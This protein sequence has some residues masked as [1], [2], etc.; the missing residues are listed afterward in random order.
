MMLVVIRIKL[1]NA[2]EYWCNNVDDCYVGINLMRL[3][4]QMNIKTINNIVHRCPNLSAWL[5]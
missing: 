4:P 3:L 2:G 1:N 5:Q